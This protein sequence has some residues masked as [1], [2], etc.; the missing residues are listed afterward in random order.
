M[1][2]LILSFFLR[3]VIRKKIYSVFRH[4]FECV[5]AHEKKKVLGG[6]D[7]VDGPFTNYFSQVV[8]YCG[9]GKHMLKD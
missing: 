1:M 7:D 2:M 8:C 3:T 6:V 9:P 4:A 5:P